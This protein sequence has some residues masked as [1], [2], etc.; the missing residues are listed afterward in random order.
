M[1]YLEYSI[2]VR[3]IVAGLVRPWKWWLF[4][5]I[6]FA[7]VWFVSSSGSKVE[8]IVRALGFVFQL[9]GFLVV[10]IGQE[11]MANKYGLPTLS[12]SFKQWTDELF[13]VKS[14][15]VKVGPATMSITS[16]L[17][18][19]TIVESELS[20]D[21]RLKRVEVKISEIKD[22]MKKDK[23]EIIDKINRCEF[24]FDSK[25]DSVVKIVEKIANDITSDRSSAISDG[26]VAFVMFLSG[27]VL[28]TFSQEIAS[29]FGL[30]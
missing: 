16:P 27:S 21:E 29:L 26:R 23:R 25:I 14:V 11:Q 7:G 9:Y 19:V 5:C 15:I 24:N 8:R 28:T 22:R 30:S 10:A 4:F 1:N 3:R 17:H 18:E 6:V 13:G 12:D 20:L 2:I